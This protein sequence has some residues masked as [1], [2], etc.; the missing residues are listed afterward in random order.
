MNLTNFPA[1][2]Q[3][4][5]D[6]TAAAQKKNHVAQFMNVQLVKL[7]CTTTKGDASQSFNVKK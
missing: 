6:V 4:T 5:D 3:V 7:H 1:A 2:L